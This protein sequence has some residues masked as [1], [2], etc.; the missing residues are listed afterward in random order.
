MGSIWPHQ[1]SPLYQR[2]RQRK[3]KTLWGL[4]LELFMA[5]S[6]WL[7]AFFCSGV[8]L[9]QFSN[10]ELYS[11]N[12]RSQYISA[13]KAVSTQFADAIAPFT[14]VFEIA[15]ADPL[16]KAVAAI[17][18]DVT[19]EEFNRSR[20]WSARYRVHHQA[21]FIPVGLS[22]VCGSTSDRHSAE[23]L[24][25]ADFFCWNSRKRN[26]IPFHAK[27]TGTAGHSGA[28]AACGN[29]VPALHWQHEVRLAASK[30]VESKLTA[31][32]APS[33]PYELIEEI[34][35][36]CLHRQCSVIFIICL[37]FG[38]AVDVSSSRLGKEVAQCDSQRN[39]DTLNRG[40]A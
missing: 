30:S 26:C 16:E 9:T 7:A 18:S 5:F 19:Y 2:L 28:I 15:D 4:Y 21:V 39:A 8:R 29:D 12:T 10:S 23:L 13:L 1:N 37:I 32:A 3:N 11:E 33:N 24:P 36:Q 17:K 25:H 27:W 34:T 6:I 38:D 31:K 22:A 40:N 20:A 14:S 35:E